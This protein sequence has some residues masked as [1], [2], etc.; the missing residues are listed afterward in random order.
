MIM[1]GLEARSEASALA[2]YIHE[3]FSHFLNI[4]FSKFESIYHFSVIYN[5]LIRLNLGQI[6]SLTVMKPFTQKGFFTAGALKTNQILYPAGYKMQAGELTTHM[7]GDMASI[8]IVTV[9]KRKYKTY[10]YEGPVNGIGKA[11]V[12]LSYPADAFGNPSALRAF[13]CMDCTLSYERRG[14]FMG[15]VSDVLEKVD[16]CVKLYSFLLVNYKI[17]K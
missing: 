6:F 16:N 17:E 3:L 2:L 13:L 5:R 7:K 14:M 12:V 11:V 15:F 4:L 10:R 1:L 9:G 8:H